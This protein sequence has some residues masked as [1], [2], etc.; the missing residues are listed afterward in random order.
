A[1]ELKHG[2]IPMVEK[3]LLDL[4]QEGLYAAS[5]GSYQILGASGCSCTV[6]PEYNAVAVSICC[7]FTT[8]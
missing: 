6:I 2:K 8:S 7:K 3:E 1:A 5:A 4:E